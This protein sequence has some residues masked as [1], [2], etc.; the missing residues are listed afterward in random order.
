MGSSKK[1]YSWGQNHYPTLNKAREAAIKT[2]LE[3]RSNGKIAISR[4]GVHAGDVE[5]YRINR[6]QI[7][8]WVVPLETEVR[9]GNSGLY[10]YYSKVAKYKLRSNG[11]TDGKIR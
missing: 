2:I 9:Y 7:M 10:V 6:E 4:N 5:Q 11:S 3:G 8:V 1:S